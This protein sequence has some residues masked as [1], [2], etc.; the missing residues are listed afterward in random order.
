MSQLLHYAETLMRTPTAAYRE[1]WVAAHI[2]R[3]LA[4]MPGRKELRTDRFGNRWIRIRRGEPRFAPVALVAHMDHPSFLVHGVEDGGRRVVGIFEGG[5]NDPYFLGTRA[6]LYRSA[7]DEGVGATVVQAGLKTGGAEGTRPVILE[8]DS[9][10]TGAVLGM[11][12]LPAFELRDG[13]VRSRAIDDL[14]GCAMILEALRRAALHN[15]DVDLIG[16]FTRAEEV[17]FRGALALARSPERHQYLPADAWVVSVETSSARP[18]T[19][20]GGGAVL[21]VGDRSSIFAPEVSAA[22]RDVSDELAATTGHRGLRRALMDGGT[23][24]ATAFVAYGWRAGGV[25]VPL[26]NYHNMN[27][28]TARIDSEY[29]AAQDMEDLAAV[30]AR[31]GCGGALAADGKGAAAKLLERLEGLADEAEPKLL[32]TAGG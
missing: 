32:A 11:W 20:I 4:E 15:G 13:M 23:C 24:E 10:A 30:M 27:V 18:T 16:L 6:R 22:L 26:G 19:P 5:V 14:G 3:F 31:L 9:D 25:C 7:Q 8:A 17:G 28:E 1:H 12:D 2:D 29:V 21:R